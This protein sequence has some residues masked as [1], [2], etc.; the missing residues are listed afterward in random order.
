MNYL[1]L[2]NLVF[3]AAATV[4]LVAGAAWSSLH[5]PIRRNYAVS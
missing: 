5:N 1:L 2:T 4:G 3:H